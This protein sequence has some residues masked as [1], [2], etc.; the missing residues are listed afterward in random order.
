MKNQLSQI[1]KDFVPDSYYETW[2]AE[3]NISL[4]KY[5]YILMEYDPTFGKRVPFAVFNFYIPT[6]DEQKVAM[7]VIVYKSCHSKSSYR[8]IV[9]F[10][11]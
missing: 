11:C 8:K 5:P 1:M 2:A 3:Y 4:I 6:V 10:G 7:A 9:Y